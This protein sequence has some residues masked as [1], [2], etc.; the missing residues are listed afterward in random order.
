MPGENLLTGI[1]FYTQTLC[2]AVSPVAAGT[3]AFFMCHICLTLLFLTLLVFYTDFLAWISAWP[4]HLIS[5]YRFSLGLL[6]L[7]RST[8]VLP[9]D[10]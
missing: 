10:R 6:D 7:S 9:V 5:L 3:A 2:I 1:T 4:L 8:F